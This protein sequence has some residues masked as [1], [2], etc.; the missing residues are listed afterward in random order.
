[1]RSLKWT[2]IIVIGMFL[3][4]APAA[5]GQVTEN[6]SDETKSCLA[7]HRNM[8][9]NIYENWSRSRMSRITPAQ[10]KEKPELERRV[11]YKELPEKYQNVVVGC[12]ECHNM[13]PDQHK[14]TFDHQGARVH[15]V[16]TPADCAVCHPFE[17][18]QFSRN[19]MSEAHGN[20]ENNPVYAD[21]T[22]STNGPLTFENMALSHGT[23]DAQTSADSC[24]FCHGTRLTVEKFE[25]RYT[26]IGP[27]EFP[28]ISG[29]PNQG[30]GRI[31]PDDSKGSCSACHTRHE[32]AIVMARKPYTCSECHKGPDVPAYKVYKVSKHANIV[33]SLAHGKEWDFNAVPWTAGEDFTAPTCATCHV[34]LVTTPDG[35]VQA[36]RTHQ[37]NDRLAWRIFGL[38]YAHAHPKSADT[39]IIKNKDGLPLPTALDGTPAAE[40]LISEKEQEKR[41]NTMKGVCQSCHTRGWVNGHFDRFEHTIETTNHQ[42]GVATQIMARAWEEKA[43]DQ[44]DS[45]FNESIERR[46]VEQ[47]LFYGNSTR[48]ASAMMGADYG[49]FANGRWYQSKNPHDMLE[50]LKV[51]LKQAE[52]KESK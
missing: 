24:L 4:A 11:S 6:L 21:L 32:F 19:L 35:R 34:S 46:W 40:Y 25:T 48:F 39:T 3:L 31:N 13:R 41:N 15:T 38:I 17:R 43:A 12:A 5:L 33:D 16:V 1:M 26:D 20:L 29:W 18:E 8:T 22:Q 42:T 49:V 14:D 36:K 7:C 47:W 50:L 51:K 52:D 45:L 23:P 30:V 2:V 27:M 37:M 44:N 28:K 10:A 9:P